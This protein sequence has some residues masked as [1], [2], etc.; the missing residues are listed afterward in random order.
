MTN[1]QIEDAFFQYL[2]IERQYSENTISSYRS[3]ITSFQTLLEI[4]YID[5][6]L[7]DAKRYYGYLRDNYANNSV[8]RKISSIK[9][10]YK[11][12]ESEKIIENNVWLSV[13]VSKRNVLLPKF[14]SVEQI[15]LLLNS[16]VGNKPI[17][18]RNKA[19]FE[20]LYA[21][22]MRISELIDLRVENVNFEERF[23]KVHGKG[24]K[25]R[26]VP[27]SDI[28][29]KYLS[30]YINHSRLS[31][32]KELTNIV[33]LNNRGNKLSRQG[34]YKIL[35]EKA[36]AVGI[37]DISPHKFRHSIAT[38]MLNEGAN[39]KVVQELLGHEN[40]S[41]TQ[42][43]SHVSSNKIINE[44]NKYHIFGKDNDEEF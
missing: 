18:V 29:C 42:I 32:M 3:D 39:L 10:M 9:S 8:L 34:F 30:L 14:L 33:F 16:L 5:L 24:N 19:M 25:Q 21:T 12:L 22:G 2:K 7:E 23:I 4:D 40:I 35:K 37:V 27:I 43:Y 44:Y 1:D 38:H 20:V 36:L 15:N 11:Y 26:I 6:T 41:T 31:L 13:H 28:A 17:D